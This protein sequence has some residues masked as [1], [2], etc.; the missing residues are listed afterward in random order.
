MCGPY[1]LITGLPS[2]SLTTRSQRALD[3]NAKD[4]RSASSNISSCVSNHL[5]KIPHRL[6]R[7]LS[8]AARVQKPVSTCS[9]SRRAASGIFPLL[10]LQS[11]IIFVLCKFNRRLCGSRKFIVA[12]LM[13]GVEHGCTTE[14]LLFVDFYIMLSDRVESVSRISSRLQVNNL[15]K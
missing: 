3:R 12:L 9:L 4:L 2:G 8:S 1:C 13:S 6:P 14:Q 5:Y 7:N 15:G 10:S 11:A